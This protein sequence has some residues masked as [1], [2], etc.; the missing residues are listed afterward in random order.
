MCLVS[1]GEFHCQ[2]GFPNDIYKFRHAVTFRPFIT[3][4]EMRSVLAFFQAKLPISLWWLTWDRCW[5]KMSFLRKLLSWQS[6]GLVYGFK[7]STGLK[8][9][10]Q[11]PEQGQVVQILILKSFFPRTG[12]MQG[13][14]DISSGPFNWWPEELC[15]VMCTTDSR[16][17]ETFRFA[18]T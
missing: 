8:V 7:G 10:P 4:N 5:C 12:Y 1:C 13:L 3:C 18:E 17:S 14:P 9:R 6:F 16:T 11:F 15:D 2:V